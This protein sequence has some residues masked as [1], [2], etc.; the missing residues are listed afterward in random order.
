MFGAATRFRRATVDSSHDNAHQ[1]NSTLHTGAVRP[2]Q[3]GG[4]HEKIDF[5]TPQPKHFNA[6]CSFSVANPS[7]NCINLGLRVERQDAQVTVD[8]LIIFYV[9]SG[10]ELKHM[11]KGKIELTWDDHFLPARRACGRRFNW[12]DRVGEP[13]LRFVF[14]PEG[15]DY[16]RH[17]KYGTQGA[18]LFFSPARRA[19]GRRFIR[20]PQAPARGLG[21]RRR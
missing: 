21:G 11:E 3:V 5:L 6:D 18:L 4:I 15:V 1:I 16:S 2:L 14:A 7:A 9:V 17:E 12:G 20:A 10:L 19:C 13:C 8:V